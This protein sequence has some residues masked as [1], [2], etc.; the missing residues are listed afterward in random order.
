MEQDSFELLV[1]IQTRGMDALSALASTTKT[2]SQNEREASAATSAF[3]KSVEGAGSAAQKADVGIGSLLDSARRASDELRK[4]AASNDTAIRNL[5]RQ[6]QLTTAK[7]AQAKLEMQRGFALQD[8]GK[9]AGDVE[10]IN[11]AYNTMS[12]SLNGVQESMVSTILKSALLVQALTMVVGAA[13]ELTIGSAQYAARTETLGVITQQL[14]RVNHLSAGSVLAHANA[15][16]QLGI[17]T[18][19]SLGT[20]NRMI[21]AQLDVAKAT[22]VARLAQD[23]GRIAGQNSSEAL[24]GIIHGIVTRQPEVLRTY[25]IVVNFEQE[26][27]KAARERGRELVAA[28]KTQVAMNVVL[29]E[30]AKITGVYAS[31][32]MTTGGRLQSMQRYLDEAKNAIGESLVPALGT[33]VTWMTKLAKLAGENSQ[34]FATLT[35]AISGAGIAYTLL[36]LLPVGRGVKIGGTIIGGVAGA[37]AGN[38]DPVKATLE[39]AKAGG[40]TLETQRKALNENLEKG[41]VKAEEYQ[42]QWDQIKENVKSFKEA[43]LTTLAKDLKKKYDGLPWI[44]TGTDANGK[45]VDQRGGSDFQTFVAREFGTT[46]W[47]G[48]F[49]PEQSKDLGHG[50]TLTAADIASTLAT[51]QKPQAGATFNQDR[52]DTEVK[53]QLAEIALEKAKKAHE[54]LVDYL[55]QLSEHGLDPFSRLVAAHIA[56]LQ[57]LKKEGASQ[58]DLGAAEVA[59]KASIARLQRQDDRVGDKTGLE[60]LQAERDLAM[61]AL[62]ELGKEGKQFAAVLRGQYDTKGRVEG[63]KDA[64]GLQKQLDRAADYDGYLPDD[65]KKRRGTAGSVLGQLQVALTNPDSKLTLNEVTNQLD[66]I[67]RELED[68]FLQQDYFKRLNDDSKKFS[69]ELKKKISEDEKKLRELEQQWE[70]LVAPERGRIEGQIATGRSK[71]DR[72]V[73]L[74]NATTMPGHELDA[75]NKVRQVQKDAAY[76]EAARQVQLADLKLKD[77]DREEAKAKALAELKEKLDN[78]E[79]DRVIKIAEMRKRDLEQFRKLPGGCMTRWW[80]RALPACWISSRGRWK[81]SSAPSFRILRWNC[82]AN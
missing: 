10:R 2:I 43:L 62:D 55:Q 29:N 66:A 79:L 58:K 47:L 81:S 9:S 11:A 44:Q 53:A 28:E 51:Q 65:L 42:R 14:A 16:K 45:R 71:T 12:T 38:T 56:K 15:V 34:A 36:S 13:K 75:L 57:D 76:E 70:V 82:T 17:T 37:I 23:A 7:T 22:D 74:I 32:L 8:M 25:G 61:Q 20:V 59:F 18:Q 49:K 64:A 77:K 40:E 68:T 35:G 52:F 63:R 19:E 50:I 54:K 26:Y 5:E 60:K 21:F 80:K 4:M 48:R 46:D 67:K 31:T 6:A 1:N 39:M 27:A 73:R 72:Q 41:L 3:G 69:D 24:Q 33:A 30:G 78:A